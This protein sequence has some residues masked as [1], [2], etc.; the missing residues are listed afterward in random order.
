MVLGGTNSE[1]LVE[2]KLVFSEA[3]NYA[4]ANFM[5]EVTYRIGDDLNVPV[6]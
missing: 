4:V 5:N 1:S 6:D 3:S 2:N